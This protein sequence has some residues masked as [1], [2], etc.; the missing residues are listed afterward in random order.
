MWGRSGDVVAS[1][2]SYSAANN[3]EQTLE[4]CDVEHP[5][6]TFIGLTQAYAAVGQLRAVAQHQQH[7]QCGA[8]QI[9]DTG[10]VEVDLAYS[11][12]LQR[13]AHRLAKNGMRTKIK[14]PL[15]VQAYGCLAAAE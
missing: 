9:A 2:F 5:L 13:L 8:V 1:V 14:A 4:P 15:K 10:Q 6:H 7:A 3:T 11:G 12:N